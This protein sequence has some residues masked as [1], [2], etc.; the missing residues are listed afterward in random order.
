MDRARRGLKVPMVLSRV[1][2]EKDTTIS[3]LSQVKG[4]FEYLTYPETDFLGKKS[5]HLEK[6]VKDEM[7]LRNR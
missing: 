4:P 5:E 1:A 7:S 2:S 6:T 3:R